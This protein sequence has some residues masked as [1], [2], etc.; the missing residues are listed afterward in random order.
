MV[1]SMFLLPAI[2]VHLPCGGMVILTGE[3]QRR[4]ERWTNAGRSTPTD[5]CRWQGMFIDTM[6]GEKLNFKATSKA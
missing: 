3:G 2:A 1:L 4:P 6:D 5:R